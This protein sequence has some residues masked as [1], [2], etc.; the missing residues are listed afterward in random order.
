MFEISLENEE[1]IP[2][3]DLLKK[4]GFCENGGHA[5]AMISQELVSVDG[6]IETRKRCKIREGKVVEF[7]GQSVKVIK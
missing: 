5:K 7:N 4:V 1:F 6:E 2:L 3:C